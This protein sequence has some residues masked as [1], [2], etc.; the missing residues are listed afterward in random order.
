MD[1]A[2]T[3][4]DSL[5]NPTRGPGHA[6]GVSEEMIHRLVHGFYAKVRSDSALGPIFDGAIGD[7]WDEHLAKMCDFWSSVTL[8]TARYKG[9]PMP[10]HVRLADVAPAHFERWLALFRQTARELCPP[11]AAALF[12]DR[13]ERIAKSLQLGIAYHRGDSP[14]WRQYRI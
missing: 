7:R 2:E 12:I 9:A 4:S 10:A 8:T 13:A 1:D 3:N 5:L 14:A 11:E 6:V